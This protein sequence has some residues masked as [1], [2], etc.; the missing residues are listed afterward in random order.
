MKPRNFP[1]RKHARRAYAVH[2]AQ[3]LPQQEGED[4]KNYGHR[5]ERHAET[6]KNTK[7][8]MTINDPRAVR[9]KINRS[10]KSFGR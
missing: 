9:T 10:L 8:N 7:L 6:I 2:V 1:A 4:D 3:P 5:L